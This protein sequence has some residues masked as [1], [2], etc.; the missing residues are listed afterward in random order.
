V[1]W[2]QHPEFQSQRVLIEGNIT[3]VEDGLM[4]L[5][6]DLEPVKVIW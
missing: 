2:Q 3:L 5:V 4:A 1:L 6:R